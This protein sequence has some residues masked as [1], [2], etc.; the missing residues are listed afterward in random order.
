MRGILTT[1]KNQ[2]LGEATASDVLDITAAADTSIALPP[3]VYRISADVPC[4]FKQGPSDVAAESQTAG[5]A[6]LGAG[7]IDVI[8]VT[9]T[10]LDGYLS[11]IYDATDTTEGKLSITRQ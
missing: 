11:A 8:H 3:G 2:Q 5:S 7:A 10:A 1:S 9:D 6:Y 4:W